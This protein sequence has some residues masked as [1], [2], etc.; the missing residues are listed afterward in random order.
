[1]PVESKVSISHFKKRPRG[2]E[3]FIQFKNKKNIIEK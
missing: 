1:M 2:C 3:I